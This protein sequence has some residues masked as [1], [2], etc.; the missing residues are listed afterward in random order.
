MNPHLLQEVFNQ[1]GYIINSFIPDKYY[2][3]IF[4]KKYVL[5]AECVIGE[6]FSKI[7]MYTSLREVY[8]ILVHDLPL[9]PLSSLPYLERIWIPNF[10]GDLTTLGECSS[11][12]EIH[13]TG[14]HNK[15][16]EHLSKFPSL[17]IIQIGSC[18]SLSSLS[19]FKSLRIISLDQYVSFE[20]GFCPH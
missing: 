4:P 11:L 18:T 6:E 17:Q 2:L 3:D 12:K 9:T 13:M 15:N 8:I 16:I 5:T 1:V 7:S 19:C 10:N 20:V 14:Y